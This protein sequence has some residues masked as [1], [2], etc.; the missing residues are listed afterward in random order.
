MLGLL[1]KLFGGKTEETVQAPYKVE[2]PVEAVTAPVNPQITDAVTQLP[3]VETKPVVAEK[4]PAKKAPKKKPAGQKPAG[5]K[6]S[7][8]KPAAPKQGGGR[9][10]KPK[11]KTQ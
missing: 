11:A 8:Q 10:R 1:K 7:G 5:Q 9:G 3:V 4:A 2:A 6:S